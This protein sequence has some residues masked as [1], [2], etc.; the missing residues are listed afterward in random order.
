MS[1][2]RQFVQ[3]EIARRCAKNPRYSLRACA[4]ALAMDPATL[5]QLVRGKRRFTART[6][7]RVG[8]A[9]G[10]DPA[11]VEDYVRR[12]EKPLRSLDQLEKDLAALVDEWQ[13]RAILELT[14]LEEFH[15]DSRWIARVL[16]TTPDQ[17]NVA[18]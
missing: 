3:S 18:L 15:A 10:L 16:G 11:A 13:H 2:F 12:E 8:T 6:I 7:R 1:P 17:V 5:S 9:L 14:S 4:R